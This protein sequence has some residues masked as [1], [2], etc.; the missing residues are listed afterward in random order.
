MARAQTNDAAV[1]TLLENAPRSADARTLARLMAQI[2]GEP[3]VVWPGSIIGFGRY[4]YTYESGRSGESCRIGFAP[5][6]AA[7]TLYL[8]SEGPLSAD[9]LAR[10]GKHTSGK[11]CLYLKALA[12]VDADV[13]RDLLSASLAD[14]RARYPD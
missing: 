10:L 7:L 9:L 12:D 5:R 13:L 4:R 3:P 1:A 8:A 2:S 14:N 11:G 6:K